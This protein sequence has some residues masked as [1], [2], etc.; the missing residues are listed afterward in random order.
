MAKSLP[1]VIV[2]LFA[3]ASAAWADRIE[4]LSGASVEG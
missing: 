3:L 2:V 4:L 1:V